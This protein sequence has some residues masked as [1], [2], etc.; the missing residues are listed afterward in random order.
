M[1]KKLPGFLLFSFLLFCNL[2][3]NSQ[4]IN[5]PSFSVKT[6]YKSIPE[7]SLKDTIGNYSSTEYE[8]GFSLP[9]FTKQFINKLNKSG[10]YSI[11][12]DN[13][14]TFIFNDIDFLKKSNIL[15]NINLGIKGIYFT[16]NKNVWIAKISSNLFEDE[17]SISNPTPRFSGILLYN[18]IVNHDFSYHFG[19]A[20]RYSFGTA[21]A[22]PVAGLKYEFANNWKLNFSLPFTGSVLFKANDKLFFLT[23]LRASGA[24]SYYTNNDNLFGLTQ[25]KLMFRKKSNTLSIDALYK[26]NSFIYIKGSIGREGS[27]KIYFSDLKTEINKEPVNYFSSKINNTWF[28][29]FG[30]NFKLSKNKKN[31][32]NNEEILDF[33]D[34]FFDL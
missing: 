8:F 28:I 5:I 29:D 24:I 9:V 16:G 21:S 12:F 4:N 33:S 18:R 6:N 13:N 34:E 1:F 32:I 2:L 19:L 14:N 23:K 11:S 15:F 26:L 10:F 3:G 17:Y 20:Y 30:I 31:P 22:L 27:R 7:Q 25:E